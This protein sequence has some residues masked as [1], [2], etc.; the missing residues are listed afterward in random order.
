MKARAK[1]EPLSLAAHFL[2]LWNETPKRVIQQTMKT[3]Q[4]VAFHQGLNCLLFF[5]DKIDL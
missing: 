1:I 4:N 5:E 2:T 3:P